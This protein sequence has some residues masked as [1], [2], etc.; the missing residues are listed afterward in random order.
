MPGN[1]VWTGDAAIRTSH[2]R[3]SQQFWSD[4]SPND[5][6]KPAGPNGAARIDHKPLLAAV[7]SLASLLR[8]LLLVVA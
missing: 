2:R 1:C 8:L 3:R 7:S 6:T 4:R 5:Q